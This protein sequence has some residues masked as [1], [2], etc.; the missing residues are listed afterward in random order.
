MRPMRCDIDLDWCTYFCP[1]G[2]SLCSRG[3]SDQEWS[4]WVEMHKPHSDG[5]VVEHT[6]ADGNRVFAEPQPD[7]VR[8]L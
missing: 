5:T 1:C 6:T 4:K 3:V 2:A 8:K 7:H